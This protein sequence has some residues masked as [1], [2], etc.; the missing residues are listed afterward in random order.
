MRQQHTAQALPL[1]PHT[2][3]PCH[4]STLFT[5]WEGGCGLSRMMTEQLGGWAWVEGHAKA[6][7]EVDIGCAIRQ[8]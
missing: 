5:A 7:L 3:P 8:M 6:L 2:A 4:S 1:R